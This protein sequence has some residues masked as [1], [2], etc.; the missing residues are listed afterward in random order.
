[1]TVTFASRGSNVYIECMMLFRSSSIA[2][3]KEWTM[4]DTLTIP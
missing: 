2:S 4:S 1:M 3:G